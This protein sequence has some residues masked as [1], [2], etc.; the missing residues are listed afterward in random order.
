MN[1]IFQHFIIIRFST[2]FKNN[3]K[4]FR[5]ARSQKFDLFSQTRLTERFFFFQ[6]ICLPSILSQTCQN[7]QCIII[8]DVRL[9]SIWKQRLEDL[10]THG[11]WGTPHTCERSGNIILH[12]WNIDDQIERT[13]FLSRYIKSETEVLITTRLDDDD[14]LHQ[15][16]VKLVQENIDPKLTF[17]IISPTNGA[18]LLLD[19][20]KKKIRCHHICTKSPSSGLTLCTDLQH[21]KLTIYFHNHSK[22]EEFYT[23]PLIRMNDQIVQNST[24]KFTTFGQ[25]RCLWYRSVHSGND[26]CTVRNYLL[27]KG[28]IL[29]D[30]K[31]ETDSGISINQSTLLQWIA[32]PP[33]ERPSQPVAKV[34]TKVKILDDECG[35]KSTVSRNRDDI[36]SRIRK[37]YKKSRNAKAS[38]AIP[39][40]NKIISNGSENIIVL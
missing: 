39:A 3:V 20:N 7:F 10:I 26:S 12:E 9:P 1:R 27:Q 35:H 23:N 13:D 15:D 16:F 11:K 34:R 14:A 29:V 25:G 32:N 2:I 4:H 28:I 40:S 17:Q 8:I 31:A 36:I 6:N 19:R 30:L 33:I 18:F 37:G 22:I 5:S 38:R 24:M 21:H